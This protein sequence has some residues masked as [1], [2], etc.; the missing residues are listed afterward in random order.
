MLRYL[1]AAVLAL[2]VLYGALEA[3]PLIAGPSLTITSPLENATFPGGIVAVEGR[4]PR[5]T[6]LSLNGMLL[7]RDQEGGFSSTLTF[8]RGGSLLT[9]VATDRFGKTVTATRAIY[10]P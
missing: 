1:I 3:W 9:F 2:L 4:A 8:P 6:E 10:V 5:A 7:L